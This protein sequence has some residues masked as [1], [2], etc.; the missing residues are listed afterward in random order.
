MG[1]SNYIHLEVERIKKVTAN[2]MLCVIDGDDVWLPLSQVSDEEDYD[3]G[4]TNVTVSITEW[5]ADQ[6]GL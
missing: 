4:D 5:L 3:E 6:R 1:A 2:A